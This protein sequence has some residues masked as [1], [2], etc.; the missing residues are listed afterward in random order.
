MAPDE[1]TTPPTS[2]GKVPEQ[3]DIPVSGRKLSPHTELDQIFSDGGPIVS[4]APKPAAFNVPATASA[5]VQDSIL[6][7][8][9][10]SQQAEWSNSSN[11]SPF[12]V[13]A[14]AAS[15]TEDETSQS[16]M[17]SQ[18]K[19]TDETNA[20][21]RWPVTAPTT[22]ETGRSLQAKTVQQDAR[23]NFGDVATIQSDSQQAISPQVHVEKDG[24]MPTPATQISVPQDSHY[25][26]NTVFLRPE[27][28]EALSTKIMTEPQTKQSSTAATDTAGDD[29]TRSDARLDRLATSV[30]STIATPSQGHVT[31]PQTTP[32]ILNATPQAFEGLAAQMQESDATFDPGDSTRSAVIGFAQDAP[33]ARSDTIGNFATPAAALAQSVSRQIAT[34][35]TQ[36][37]DQPVEIAL[38]PEELGKVRLILHAS[39][40]SM[41][42]TV[43]AERPETLDLMR[44]NINMLA[45]DMRDLGYSELSF[46]FSDHPQQR[47]GHAESEATAQGLNGGSNRNVETVASVPPP[48]KPPYDANTSELDLRI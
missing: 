37:P 14:A 10:A 21:S 19:T 27:T 35:V 30:P 34:A 5:L 45:A 32:P 17:S 13:Q 8:S 4:G 43:Q 47:S 46:S 25:T 41:I 26:S 48:L 15:S 31:A 23:H 11:S 2:S 1:D 39:E 33:A 28:S 38:S 12:A 7:T 24:K 6:A 16:K 22:Q 3:F 36:M 44:R 42:V 29:G 9:N 20:T 40:H 18:T